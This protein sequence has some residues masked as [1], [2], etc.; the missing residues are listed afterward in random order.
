MHRGTAPFIRELPFGWQ[1]QNDAEIAH[2]EEHIELW[3]QFA[4]ALEIRIDEAE[5]PAVRQLIHTARQLFADP[6]TAL[7]ALYAFEV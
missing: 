7:G 5:R 2:E 1:S 4:H 6:V 3:E